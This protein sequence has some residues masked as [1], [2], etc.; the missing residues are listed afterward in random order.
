[1][2]VLRAQLLEQRDRLGEWLGPLL[3]AVRLVGRGLATT[4]D[5]GDV[6]PLAHQVEDRLVVTPGCR[7]VEGREAV[8]VPQI[9]IDAEL[10]DEVLHGGKPPVRYGPVRLSDAGGAEAHSRSR[11]DRVDRRAPMGNGLQAGGVQR[12]LFIVLRVVRYVRVDGLTRARQVLCPDVRIGTVVYQQ[13]HGRYIGGVGRPPERRRPREVHAHPPRVVRG[14]PD[15]RLGLLI[16]VGPGLEQQ[17]H[18]IQ[19]GRLLLAERLRLWIPRP[20]RPLDV[21]RGEQRTRSVV[22]EQVGVRVG[23]EQHPRQIVV[24][25]DGRDQQGGRLIPRGHLIDIGSGF[26]QETSRLD[27]SFASGKVE[28]GEPTL[29]SDLLR[30]RPDLRQARRDTGCPA[31]VCPA[32]VVVT[33]TRLLAIALRLGGFGGCADPVPTGPVGVGG[34]R[35]LDVVLHVCGGR[36]IGVGSD[37]RLGRIDGA[38]VRSEHQRCPARER[39]P[40]VHFSTVLDERTDGLCRVCLCREV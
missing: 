29:L 24:A 12:I 10:F 35:D 11:V 15:V 40:G 22:A 14:V 18:Q 21:E 26:H 3:G 31:G 8:L 13:S 2:V 5:Q 25:V 28:G 23:V 9:R 36:E 1:M 30:G 32:G 16:R 4:A 6:R 34:R 37:Q 19:I 39:I 33:S 17:L 20:E 7:M 27:V 38:S